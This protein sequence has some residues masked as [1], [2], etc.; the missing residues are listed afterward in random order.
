M[1]NKVI[2]TEFCSYPRSRKATQ[3]C[4]HE[5][6]HFTL[7]TRRRSQC[8]SVIWLLD[9]LICYVFRWHDRPVYCTFVHAAKFDSHNSLTLGLHRIS[10]PASASAEIRHIFITGRP[11]MA[12]GYE[13]DWTYILNFEFFDTSASLSNFAEK[14]TFL[15]YNASLISW[16]NL[17]TVFCDLKLC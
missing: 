15:K 9:M 3:C 14:V 16:L 1:V 8:T 7:A 4:R 12:A 11:D 13:A 5:G 10:Y 6:R 17:I 2:Q